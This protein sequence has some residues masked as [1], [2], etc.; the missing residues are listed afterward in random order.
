MKFIDLKK[1]LEK[2][3]NG[4]FE[5]SKIVVKAS[6]NLYKT[7]YIDLFLANDKN[8]LINGIALNDMFHI[9]FK[10][11]VDTSNGEFEE[12]I[13]DDLELPENLVLENLYNSISITPENKYFA[14]SSV[15]VKFRK[16]KG[17][18]TKILKGF[19]KYVDN[20]YNTVVDLK[21]N[22]K[23]HD[24]FKTLVDSKI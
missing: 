5:K 11:G 2:I 24:N 6:N 9:T 7:I 19:E 20:L 15:S 14:Y 12:N 4:K 3:Y 21:N 22:G 16:I 17:N 10:I 13:T 1:E 23:I 18:Y 8:E